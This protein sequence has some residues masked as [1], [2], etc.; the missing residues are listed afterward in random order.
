MHTINVGRPRTY[1]RHGLT[2][3][4]IVNIW[5]NMVR[6]CENKKNTRYHKYGGRGIKCEWKDFSE[7][8]KDMG[9]SY[10]RHVKRHGEINTTLERINNDWNYCKSN[11][12]WAT[13]HE[14][15][16]NTARN[17]WLEYNGIRMVVQDW[18]KKIKITQPALIAR[19]KRWGIKRALSTP[20]IKEEKFVYFKGKKY[21]VTDLA[22]QLNLPK[23]TLFSRINRGWKGDKIGKKV[24]AI[25]AITEK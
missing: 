21:Q 7:F 13:Q 24:K 14:Q 3:S 5:T 17:V 6:R 1:I 8:F 10:D 11:C 22:R 18:A 19:L 4:R 16:R 2:N 12:R 25:N 20:K 15:M 23:S 9:A